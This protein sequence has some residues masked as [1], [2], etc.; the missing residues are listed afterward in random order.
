MPS[1]SS[2]SPTPLNSLLT[3]PFTWLQVTSWKTGLILV[4][5]FSLQAKQDISLPLSEHRPW[6]TLLINHGGFCLGPVRTLSDTTTALPDPV[7][8]ALPGASVAASSGQIPQSLRVKHTLLPL[9]SPPSTQTANY[10]PGRTS[11]S[12]LTQAGG[13]VSHHPILPASADSVNSSQ[14]L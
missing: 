8:P 10:P 14:P 1:P 11:F 2:P 4:T 3:S 5:Q 9:S 6:Q 7:I 12:L 13:D